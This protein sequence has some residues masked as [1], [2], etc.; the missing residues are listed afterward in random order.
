MIE[1]FFYG[2]RGALAF[3][4]PSSDP[5]ATRLMVLCPPLFDEYRR[6]YKALSD[7]ATACAANGVHVLRIDYSG[8]GE[9]QGM[10]SDVSAQDWID[11]ITQAIEEGIALTGAD[12]AI[13]VGVRFGATLAA[14]V[15][16]PAVDRFVFWD[17]LE[18]GET[19]LAWLDQLEQ[20]SRERHL[21][22]AKMVNREP[23]DISYAC[24]QLSDS[25]S[26][27]LIS[28]KLDSFIANNAERLWVLSTN[29]DVG[30]QEHF[31]NFEFAGYEYDWPA[32][33]EGNFTPKPVL[34]GIAQKVLMI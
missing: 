11:D 27:S 34:E 25:L 16:H 29:S 23:E 7:L 1:P 17:P 12:S 21:N 13:L 9:A 4:H 5:A 3:Y 2:D 31:K 22:L 26:T 19:Y 28:L 18:N 30:A 8:T 33:H 10:L 32:F 15:N 24:F 14:Q 20:R 6:T